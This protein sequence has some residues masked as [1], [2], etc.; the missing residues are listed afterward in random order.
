MN[1]ELEKIQQSLKLLM[2]SK[3]STYEQMAKA[4]KISPATVKRRLNGSDITLQHLKEF[5]DTLSISFY[6]LIEFSKNIKREPHL[7]TDSQEELLAFKLV[8]M[9][10]FRSILAGISYE[11]IK[12]ELKISDKDLR[13][14]AKD[15]EKTGLAQLNPKDRFIPLVHFPF[16]WQQNGPLSKAYEPLILQ[17]IIEKMK[18][19]KKEKALN[20]KFEFA[21]SPE[22][23]K[24]FCQEIESIYAKY[25]TLSELQLSSKIDNNHLVSGLLFVDQFS[26]W[27]QSKKAL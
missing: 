3:K 6:E 9:L 15:F 5:A 2:K 13:K 27:D 26:I 8:N 24:N 20:K 19:S 10:A 25:Q 22:A 7:F 12:F 1:Y 18:T 17:N 4:L 16:K 14:L 21:L 23:Q 11:K